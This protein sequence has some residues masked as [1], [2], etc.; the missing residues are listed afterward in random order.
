VIQHHPHRA[1]AHFGFMLVRCLAHKGSTF[2]GVGASRKTGAVQSSPAGTQCL[3]LIK[4]YFPRKAAFIWNSV[5]T[6]PTINAP[7]PTYQE[8]EF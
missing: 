2:S 8:T 4:N 7:N 5:H 3:H 1:F 6:F